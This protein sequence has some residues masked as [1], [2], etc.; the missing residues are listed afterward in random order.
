MREIF[1]DFVIPSSVSDKKVKVGLPDLTARYEF[2]CFERLGS[3][4]CSQDEI[5]ECRLMHREGSVSLFLKNDVVSDHLSSF[6]LLFC[7]N[8]RHKWLLFV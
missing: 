2:L 5:E 4:R 1:P 6:N 3:A 8:D 7:P